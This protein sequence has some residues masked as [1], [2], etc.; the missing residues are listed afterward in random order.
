[1]AGKI[2]AGA[3]IHR[4]ALA[5][6][7]REMSVEQGKFACRHFGTLAFDS[8]AVEGSDKAGAIRARPAMH[9]D[10]LR[11]IAQDGKNFFDLVGY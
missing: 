6:E 9:Q 2:N 1:M 10:R 3:L 5:R 8:V 11:R 7:I 4:P